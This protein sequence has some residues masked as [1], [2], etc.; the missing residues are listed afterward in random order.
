MLM[1]TVIL[2]YF[3]YN[4]L[5]SENS[6]NSMVGSVKLTFSELV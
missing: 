2:F 5:I 1:R 3:T 6:P 4:N